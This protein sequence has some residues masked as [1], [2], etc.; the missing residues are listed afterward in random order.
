MMERVYKFVLLILILTFNFT[1]KLLADEPI[2]VRQMEVVKNDTVFMHHFIYNQSNQKTIDTQYL[3]ENNKLIRQNQTEWIYSNGKCTEQRIRQWKNN[4]WEEV[5]LI[6]FNYVNGKKNREIYVN[7][8]GGTEIFVSKTNF[9][10]SG[11]N[12]ISKTDFQWI[13]NSWQKVQKNNY[14]YNSENLP[15][16]TTLFI[17]E[18]GVIKNQRKVEYSYSENNQLLTTTFLLYKDNAWEN[19]Q[20]T[21][22]YY[23]KVT[24]KK[25]LEVT[26]N[27]DN[28]YNTWINK[29]KTQYKYN[30]DLNILETN[31]QHW[32]GLF[33]KNDVKYNF[34]YNAEKQLVTK[35]TYL[36]IY[37]DYR[38]A[39]EVNYT[40]FLHNKA[41]LIKSKNLFWGGQ[42]NALRNTFIPFEFNNEMMIKNAS[43]IQISYTP[44]DNTG[45][46]TPTIQASNKMINVYPNPSK[47]VF[48]FNSDGFDVYNWVITDIK[49]KVL[50]E[51]KN[52]NHSQMIDLGGFRNG[53][54]LLQVN[55]SEGIKTQKLI[56]I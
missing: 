25:I 15:Q 47:G 23:D 29:Q 6:S 35:Q 20:Q 33:W 16:T 18:N 53:I 1:I 45:I 56:K 8:S 37:N 24:D 52:P 38:L 5:F 28:N 21:I 43:Q 44:F 19:E 42:T 34:V 27:W 26:K 3:K 50:L 36:P 31:Y 10:Y 9:F 55:S 54:Y 39:A 49:G 14:T 7:V 4:N 11:D 40:D 17:Y 13:N 12:L 22:F 41:S 46:S 51:N 2:L 32:S 30:Q 48:Y